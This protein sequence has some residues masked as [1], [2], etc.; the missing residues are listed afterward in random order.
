M[1]ISGIGHTCE[2]VRSNAQTT[3]ALGAA[4]PH[5]G[6]PELAPTTEVRACAQTPYS[7]CCRVAYG[8]THS[9]AGSRSRAP[10]QE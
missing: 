3:D 4:T 10:T 5:I 2:H 7:R 1:G 8:R 6:R 9:K